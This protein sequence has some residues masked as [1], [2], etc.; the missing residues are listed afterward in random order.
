LLDMVAPE[1]ATEASAVNVGQASRLP[2][3]RERFR[4]ALLGGGR[5][6]ACP[7]FARYV[8]RRFHHR[9]GDGFHGERAGHARFAGVRERLV[10]K[11]FRL[12]RFVVGDGA[13]SSVLRRFVF[14]TAVHAFVGMCHYAAG[15]SRFR[16]RR[17]IRTVSR[18][19]PGQSG[20]PQ[21]L[22]NAHRFV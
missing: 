12:G 10:V 5:R 6:D 21:I 3:E 17:K 11:R 13:R 7:I 16:F 18:C 22:F 20:I 19:T 9:R 14:Q 8:S 15:G 4:L 1:R 2:R